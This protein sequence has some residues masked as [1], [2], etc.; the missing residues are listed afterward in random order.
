MHGDAVGDRHRLLLVVGDDQRRHGDLLVQPAQ[1][2]AQLG[3][4]LR[5]ERAERLVEQQQPRL[6]G[7]RPRQR[8]PLALAAGELVGV[9]LGVARE[10]RRSPSS[11]DV[12]ARDPRLGLL[13]HLQAEGDVVAHGHVPEGGV[14]LEDEADPAPLR[15]D[16][17]HVLAVDQDACRR[18]AARGRR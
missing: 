13:A 16:V 6:D 9:A 8:H 10:A 4:D 14:V 1:P 3:A 7:E 5:V 17:R 12:R 15:R 11:S 18:R 2:L